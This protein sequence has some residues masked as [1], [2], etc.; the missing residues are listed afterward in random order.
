VKSFQGEQAAE[1]VV[2][3]DGLRGDRQWGVRDAA[4]G[5]V[6]TGRREP[7]LLHASARL[8]AD[9]AEIYLPTGAVCHGTGPAT[10]DA[11]SAWLGASVSLVDAGTQPPS[12][13]E[14]FA[15]AIDDSSA[16]I[17]WTMP[18]GRFVDAAPL[19]VLT[20]ASL[21]SGASLHPAGNWDV[22]RFRPNVLIDTDHDGWYEDGWCG[23]TVHV[24]DVTL[25]PQQPCVRCTMVTR[26][27]PGLE[28]DI[29]V[30]RA[31]A[32]HHNGNLGV[33]TAVQTPG[34]IRVG[35]AVVIE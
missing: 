1:V 12:Q 30:Y 10:D 11:L 17:E 15:D 8:V 18:S 26:P 32:R 22:R 24:G 29:D 3:P 33:W 9:Q 19:L 20:T 35:D 2:E 6:L 25:V 5:R 7:R 16:A 21:R 13:A 4:S 31:V 27:Q 14:Y 28:R 34:Q 23:R